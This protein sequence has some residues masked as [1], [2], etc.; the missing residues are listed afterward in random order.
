MQLL[1]PSG[2]VQMPWNNGG[3][4]TT[5]IARFPGEGD[6]DW[7]V[8]VAQVAEDGPF[9]RFPGCDRVI[10]TLEGAGMTL[11]H[12]DQRGANVLGPRE[13][14]RF[15]GDLET[16]C[17][18]RDGPIRDFNVITRRGRFR[19]ALSIVKIR[20]PAMLDVAQLTLLYVVTGG[21]TVDDVT[22]G[23]DETVVVDG[24]A[25]CAGDG[26]TVIRVDLLRA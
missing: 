5:E 14:Y 4:V 10:L 18:L 22:A 6:F 11:M 26:A 8:S 20:E 12:R 23:P 2:Y 19:S 7:R 1:R 25:R 3:G 9:S 24:N 15:S 17:V 16:D 21:M 13:P